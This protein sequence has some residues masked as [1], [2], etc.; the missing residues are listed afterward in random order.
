MS[1]QTAT[2]YG[3]VLL[4]PADAARMAQ[5]SCE[6][7]YREIDRGKLPARHVGRQLRIDPADFRAYLN[8]A[9]GA[10]PCHTPE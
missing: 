5:V 8:R 9:E 1:T 3:T 6:T 4:S 10:V 2:R 7:I